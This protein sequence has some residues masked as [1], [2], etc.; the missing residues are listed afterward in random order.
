MGL[1]VAA[2]FNKGSDARRAYHGIEGA[3]AR[4]KLALSVYRFH[5]DPYWYVAVVGDET[6]LSRFVPLAEIL[7]RHGQII[8]LPDVT[9]DELLAHRAKHLTPS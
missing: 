3:L 6:D 5:S 8:A 7:A 1:S 2:R 9:H 4:S